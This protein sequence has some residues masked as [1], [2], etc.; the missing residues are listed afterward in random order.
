MRKIRIKKNQISNK[1]Y[2][3]IFRVKFDHLRFLI[4]S[5]EVF[6]N[7]PP[8]APQESTNF[9]NLVSNF[10]SDKYLESYL[11]SDNL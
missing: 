10:V 4:E 9:A 5:T 11:N 1:L 7:N 2:A 6:I 3:N 8:E